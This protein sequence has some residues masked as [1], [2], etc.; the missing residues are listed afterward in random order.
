MTAR[1]DLANICAAGAWLVTAVLAITVGACAQTGG[2]GSEDHVRVLAWNVSRDA[3]VRDPEAFAAVVRKARADVLLLDEVA[4]ST[5]EGQLRETLAGLAL[6]GKDDWYVDFGESGGRQRGVVVSRFPLERV[7]EFADTVPYPESDRR[8]LLD[9]MTAANQLRPNYSM[10]GGIPVNGVIVTAGERRLLVV[11]TDLQCCG[12][13]PGGWQEDRRRVET[14][15]IRRRVRLVLERTRI[16]GIVLAGDFNAVSTPLPLI[17]AS[18]PYPQPHAGL[19]A[20]ELRHL[21]GVET[22]TN[23]ANRFPNQALD[24]MLYSPRTLEL[25]EGYVLDTADLPPGELAQLGLESESAHD[26]SSHR[27]LVAEFVWR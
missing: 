12:A 16:D 6:G 17:L 22:W 19:I 23:R 18:G 9:R 11:T 2:E 21:D 13:D 4:P 20:A 8:R 24:F 14:G 15:E 25:R 27:P 7:P 26:L 5:N 1:D 10:D 3:F